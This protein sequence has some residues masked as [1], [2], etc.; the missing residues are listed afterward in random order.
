MGLDPLYWIT[1]ANIPGTS[2]CRI[3]DRLDDVI[4]VGLEDPQ[5]ADVDPAAVERV[6]G[7]VEAL[8]RT[9]VHPALQIQVRRHGVV[10]L[11]RAIGHARGN[12]PDDPPDAEKVPA[13][14]ATPFDLYS[15]SKA[16]TAMVIHKLDEQHALHLEDRVCDYIPEFERHGKHRIT[17]RHLLAHRAG[18]PNLP[19][20]AID[21]DLLA[22]PERVVE[23]LCDAELRT[24]PGRLLAYHAVSGGF[25]L[26]EVVRRVTGDDI[27]TVLAREICEPLGL[28]WLRYGVRPEDLPLVARDALTGPPVPP[29]LSTLLRNALGAELPRVIE[30][31][32]D[33]RFLTGIIPSA[34]VVSNADELC[35]FY[36][37]LLDEGTLRGTRV[38]EPRTIRHA[39]A[40]SSYWEVDLTLGVPL[41]YGLGFM[42]GS[43]GPNL[44]GWDNPSAFGH[45]GF[46]NIFSWAD[47]ARD[48]AV[49]LLSSGKPVLSLH[50]IRLVQ[51]LVEVHRAFPRTRAGDAH[52]ASARDAA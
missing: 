51:W 41:R 21:L 38:F 42:L 49:V 5:R 52:P 12:A 39:T 11:H 48:L 7:A 18:I 10:V 35:A 2:R 28:R 40:E 50:A 30:L 14:T 19:P 17:L 27:R 32:N 33:P 43:R 46:S 23:I 24:R 22:H 37:C 36:Q 3:P 25:V 8:Y 1:R 20:D 4:H 47:P 31:A 16:V 29:P 9:G 45:L 44:F 13:T 15:A 6:W 34:N 26:G